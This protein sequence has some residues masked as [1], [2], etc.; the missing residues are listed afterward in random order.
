VTQAAARTS[1]LRRT[2][3]C[4]DFDCHVYLQKSHPRPDGWLI[5]RY[6]MNSEL[7]DSSLLIR[8]IVSA[9]SSATDS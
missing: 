9:S 1:A 7:T 4:V 8:S 3:C 6:S 5:K 2:R